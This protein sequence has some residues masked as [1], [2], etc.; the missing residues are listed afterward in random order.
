M[1]VKNARWRARSMRST[2]RKNNRV[3]PQCLKM[4]AIV[5]VIS[6]EHSSR[7]H[8]FPNPRSIF[9][10]SGES[11]CLVNAWL[12]L[13]TRHFSRRRAGGQVGII[14]VWGEVASLSLY[15]P[16]IK[17]KFLFFEIKRGRRLLHFLPCSFL[18]REIT[19]P[20][21]SRTWTCWKFRRA[22][23]HKSNKTVSTNK[24]RKESRARPRS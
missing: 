20:W 21:K 24:R 3:G 23:G 11:R 7:R 1:L 17:T 18:K 8:S 6:H 4:I 19:Q 22:Y 16:Y 10:L 9:C 15:P 5:G 2:F 12:G 13:I 14:K